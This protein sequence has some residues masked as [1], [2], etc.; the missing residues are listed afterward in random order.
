[1]GKVVNTAMTLGGAF[2]SGGWWGVG[3][4]GVGMLLGSGQKTQGQRLQDLGVQLAQEGAELPKG[5][6]FWRQ[7]GVL[8]YSPGLDE[9]KEEVDGKGGPSVT[10]YTYDGTWF[11][12]GGMGPITR[13]KRIRLNEKVYYDWNNGNER[14]FT[15]T[16]ANN[17]WTSNK[18][19]R[20]RIYPGLFNQ[21][22]DSYLETE[23]GI[24]MWTAYPGLWGVFFE[25]QA[26]EKYGNQ[27]PNC[28]FDVY[29]AVT[30]LSA[31][32][33]EICSWRSL[34][35]DDLDLHELEG[36]SV[37]PRDDEG[38]VVANRK[39]GASAI[40]ELGYLHNFTL[41]EGNGVI[42]AVRRGRV[43]VAVLRG[44]EILQKSDGDETPVFEQ[45]MADAA[46]LPLAGEINFSDPGRENFPGLRVVKRAGAF[47]DS[48][49]GARGGRR[50]S[51]SITASMNAG[52]AHRAAKIALYEKAA[53]AEAFPLSW[54]LRHLRL[55]PADTIQIE[56]PEGLKEVE[57]PQTNQP[58][59]GPTTS[60]ATGL[61][62][63][64]YTLPIRDEAPDWESPL[65]DGE[66]APIG[67]L[68][69]CVAL[70]ENSPDMIAK[71]G[72]LM[73][74][75]QIAGRDWGHV[76]MQ[77]EV[78]ETEGW[79]KKEEPLI[80]KTRATMGYLRAPWTPNPP[81]AGYTNDNP[82]PVRLYNGELH[83]A[84]PEQVAV[85][86]N[87]MVFENGLVVSFTTAAAGVGND[88]TLTGVKAG[89][90][91]SDYPQ[92]GIGS[93][94]AN[95]AR[96]G[97]ALPTNAKFVL[98]V[99]EEG[100]KMPARFRTLESKHIGKN[101]RCKFI[102]RYGDDRTENTQIEQLETTWRA[103]N[104]EPLS[105]S[106]VRAVRE[107]GGLRLTGRSRTR[108]PEGNRLSEKPTSQGFKYEVVL[109]SGAFSTSVTKYTSDP[110][111]N[112]DFAWTSAQ[113]ASALGRTVAQ[114]EAAPV[115][116][117]VAMWGDRGFGRTT[118]FSAAP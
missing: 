44:R 51:T 4:A 11:V 115:G 89:R 7:S 3:L 81:E 1:M 24:G 80:A 49:R 31:V 71:P 29:N 69:D 46:E 118:L 75:T 65:P 88:Y 62:R 38:Y 117:S 92:A 106:G 32:V 60:L 55:L 2:L 109:T 28:T 20:F 33:A 26:L 59:F 58:F 57:L 101:L 79:K 41:R 95:A 108:F 9:N 96:V 61:D 42:E 5:W 15:T 90:W 45:K 39:S 25:G 8:V 74:A 43:A 107:N 94:H 83:S 21:P 116:G 82:M 87:V 52:R 98:L 76:A 91:G 16:Y 111:A 78:E 17:H 104:I 70:S 27:I 30:D 13:I 113:L 48:S 19:G 68:C 102:P 18:N 99:N 112:F 37:A 22:I 72:V 86:H 54:G 6:G 103:R 50:D 73:A 35:E 47:D 67:F 63:L 53:R 36:I 40:E 85:G 84:T 97:E 23:K 110:D 12:I 105:P 14:R 56:T 93:P 66:S 100:E 34:F 10:E 114:I 64:I 77:I